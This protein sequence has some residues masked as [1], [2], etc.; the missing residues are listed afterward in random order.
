MELQWNWSATVPVFSE[1]IF[2]NM[3]SLQLLL[4][5]P[6]CLMNCVLGTQRLSTEFSGA[7]GIYIS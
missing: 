1:V 4:C 3:L 5:G 7:M 6:D 2:I